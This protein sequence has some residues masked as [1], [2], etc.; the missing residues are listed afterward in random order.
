MIE[1]KDLKNLKEANEKTIADN[2]AII[3]NAKVQNAE[4]EAENRVFDKLI[5]LYEPE[6]AV[7]NVENI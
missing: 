3:E 6:E 1:V 4:L 2:N 5:K 7:E